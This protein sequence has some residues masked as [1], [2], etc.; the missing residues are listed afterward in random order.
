MIFLETG[1]HI[2]EEILT[3]RVGPTSTRPVEPLSMTICDFDDVQYKLT[4]T[5]SS[6][7]SVA[8][9]ELNM[10]YR[11]YKELEKFGAKS[12]LQEHY[13]QVEIVS[14][15]NSGFDLTLRV[16]LSDFPPDKTTQLITQWSNLKRNV[17][18]AP[19]EQSFKALSA[20]SSAA[21]SPIQIPFRKNETMYIQPQAD[22]I[23]LVFS[24]VF[25]DKTDQALARVFL[26]E[27][28]ETG[29]RVNNAPPIAFAREPP[30]ELRHVS[31]LRASSDLVGYLSIAVFPSHVA[32]DA[33]RLQA[34]SMVQ[35]FRNYLHYHIKSTKSYLH[36]RMRQRVEMLLQVLNRAHPKHDFNA[37]NVSGKKTISGK[38]F[39]R[40]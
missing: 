34:A 25:A 36:S 18:I 22:R 15:P 19:L 31:T 28:A 20:G 17:L 9:M 5:E 11:P 37:T 16:Q 40:S 14:P 39:T 10:I 6:S 26:Q 12:Y 27:M 21:L 7:D 2:L 1:N 32:T 13:T 3:Q 35:G 8:V 38:T 23:I 30:L 29:R 33:K 24:I 4:I